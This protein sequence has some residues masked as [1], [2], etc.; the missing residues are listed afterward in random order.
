MSYEDVK[1]FV[2]EARRITQGWDSH[3]YGVIVG[4]PGAFGFNT[5]I[6]VGPGYE[7]FSTFDR[8]TPETAEAVL[9]TLR[10]LVYGHL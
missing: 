6:I 8:L 1:E 2:K 9:K 3:R 7:F 4:E 10:A 5:V